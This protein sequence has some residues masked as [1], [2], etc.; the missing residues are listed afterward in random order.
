MTSIFSI[1]GD[2]GCSDN[3]GG[4]SHLCLAKRSPMKYTCMCPAGKVITDDQHTC[5]G[6]NPT[7]K[8]PFQKLIITIF[9]MF[10]VIFSIVGPKCLI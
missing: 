5:E 1:S 3:N 8:I 2:N 4:C 9:F 10:S 6:K 7:S